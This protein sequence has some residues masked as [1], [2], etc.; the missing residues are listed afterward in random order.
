MLFF[1]KLNTW[2]NFSMVGLLSFQ[3]W[4]SYGI[5]LMVIT[6]FSLCWLSLVA[7]KNINFGSKAHQS[8]TIIMYRRYIMEKWIKVINNKGFD[9]ASQACE[10][11]LNVGLDK[12]KS[13]VF[14]YIPKYRNEYLVVH[15]LIIV[16]TK[17]FFD[18]SLFT[19]WAFNSNLWYFLYSK[20]SKF[21]HSILLMGKLKI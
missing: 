8:V 17:G 3:D 7:P 15:L 20:V 11:K 13:S 9:H 12:M 18:I 14:I 21:C 16:N 4:H 1:H 6:R 10:N 19:K 2:T 5:I